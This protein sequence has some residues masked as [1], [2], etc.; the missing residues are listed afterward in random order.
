MKAATLPS[1]FR[2]LTLVV[3][4]GAL[5]G[6]VLAQGLL[7]DF[8][9]VVPLHLQIQNQQKRELLRFSNGIANTG[10]GHARFR[11]GFPLKG[12]GTQKAIQEILD[13]DGN[14]VGEFVVGEFEFHPEHKHFHINDVARFAVHADS[15]DGPAVGV[16]SI[17]VTFCLIDLYKL[18]GNSKT[19]ERTY[20]DCFGDHQGISPGWVDQ[21]HQSTEGQQ[22]DITGAPPGLYYLVSTSNPERAFLEA[23]YSNNTAW[24]SFK[25]SRESKGNPKIKITGHSDCAS[26]GLCGEGA[27]NP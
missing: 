19:P 27:P 2:L 1:T 5:P 7:P 23:D 24:V 20:W 21:Y 14:V 11:P 18:E 4:L 26:P 13:A 9:T 8:Q 15:P 16:G 12:T 3:G 10:D 6:L 25:L 17:K 22:L